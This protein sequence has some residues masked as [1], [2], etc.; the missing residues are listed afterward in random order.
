M[1]TLS[2][3]DGFIW[4]C[5]NV[6]EKISSVH[7]FHDDANDFTILENIKEFHD[8]RVTQVSQ[9]VDLVP[10]GTCPV[11]GEAEPALVNDF[12]GN[13]NVEFKFYFYIGV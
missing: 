8:P 9:D 10:Q 3:R 4:S 12:D 1:F 7:F 11:V 5:E 6:F 2:F 13:W